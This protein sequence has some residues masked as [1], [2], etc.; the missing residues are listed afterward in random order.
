M[1]KSEF[2]N[3]ASER[4]FTTHYSG[5][6]KKHFLRPILGFKININAIINNKTLC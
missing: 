1:N 4:G 3:Y 6:L 5:K 2:K